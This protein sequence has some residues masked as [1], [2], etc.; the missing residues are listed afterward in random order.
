MK[1]SV[2]VNIPGQE[3]FC[4]KCNVLAMEP[5]TNWSIANLNYKLAWNFLLTAGDMVKIG[6]K[7][8]RDHPTM[9]AIGLIVSRVRDYHSITSVHSKIWKERDPC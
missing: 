2:H 4:T 7:H 1:Y 5:V 3:F 9:I 6:R 8:I